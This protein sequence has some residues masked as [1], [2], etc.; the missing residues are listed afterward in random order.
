MKNPLSASVDFIMRSPVFFVKSA[1]KQL[2]LSSSM[3][4]SISNAE[5]A[6]KEA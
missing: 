5:M 6:G 4:P 1:R 3:G 2:I